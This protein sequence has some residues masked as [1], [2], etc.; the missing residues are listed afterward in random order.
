MHY[1]LFFA[2]YIEKNKN[3]QKTER[4]LSEKTHFKKSKEQGGQREKYSLHSIFYIFF[5]KF[6]LHF[7]LKKRFLHAERKPLFEKKIRSSF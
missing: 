7:L 3:T 5:L 4:I 2:K 1:L 6:G